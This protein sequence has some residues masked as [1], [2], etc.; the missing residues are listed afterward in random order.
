MILVGLGANLPSRFGNPPATIAA[1]IAALAG[2]N[3]TVTAQSRIWLTA[4]VPV[5]DQ[6]WYHNAVIA[7]STEL[8]PHGLLAVLQSVENEFGRVRQERNEPRVIDLDLLAYHGQHMDDPDLILPHPRLHQRGFVLWPL[9]DIAPGWAH[10][11]SGATLQDMLAA[12]P[13]DQAAQPW[14][15]AA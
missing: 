3:L 14:E 13:P 15:D 7:V 9:K 11:V 6:P 2:R 12:L 1:A 8:P 5:S 10:P 4:P